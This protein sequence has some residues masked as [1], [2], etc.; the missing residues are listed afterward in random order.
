MSMSQVKEVKC[1]SYSNGNLR[2]MQTNAG[3]NWK[4]NMDN[5]QFI[6]FGKTVKDEDD[7]LF[8]PI[9]PEILDIEINTD[10]CGIHGTPCK[11][12]YKSNIVTGTYMPFENFVKVVN[13][14]NPCNNLTQLALGVGN[15]DGNPDLI[16][17]LKWCRENNIVPN[18]T[19]NGARLD[20]VYDGLTYA[21]WIAKYCGAVAVSHYEDDICFDSVK[22][23]TDLGM[24]QVNIHKI[25]S[26]ETIDDCFRLVEIK[27]NNKDE[28]LAK[29]NAIVFLSL[30]KKGIRNN[31]QPIGND[32]LSITKYRQLISFAIDNNV[33]IG[34]DSCGA[35][36][37]IDAIK[38]N[39]EYKPLMQLAEPCEAT[40]F[41]FYVNV[42]GKYYPCSF[43]EGECH[44]DI[45][46]SEGIDL[47]NENVDFFK[48]VW[49]SE[50]VVNFRKSLIDNKRNCLI[51]EV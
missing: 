18:I 5:G 19:V 46:W 4:M 20:K 35:N 11:W 6:R 41:S 45:D 39:E 7:P 32:A 24:T 23:F 26:K 15:V 1:R 2:C 51:F 13:K 12:C 9:G 42:D 48:D 50:K 31:L 27:S 44:K 30:K 3:Y 25:L 37:F 29:L 10:C 14:V 28:R 38:D 22:K 16:K 33:G 47:L 8:S 43:C 21:E 36:R 34:F 40:C 17:I 49:Y